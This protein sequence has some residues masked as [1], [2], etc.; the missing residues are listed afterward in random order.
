MVLVELDNEAILVEAMRNRTSGEMIRAYQKL[1]DRMKACGVAP[2]HHV[3]D[4]E[5]SREF[6]E[7][8]KENQ[9]TYQLADAHDHRRNI[10]EKVIQTFKDHFVAV[11]CGA[12]DTFPMHLWDRLLEQAEHQLNMLRPSRVVPTISAYAYLYGNHDYNAQPFAP[13]ACK[14]QMHEMPDTRKSWDVHTVT[15]WYIGVSWEHY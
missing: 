7:A 4:N 2:K 6:K 5:C 13:L 3:L 10:A 9:M 8:I 1:V 15:G 14:V 11:L 12:D